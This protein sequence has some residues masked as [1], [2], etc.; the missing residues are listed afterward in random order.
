MGGPGAGAVPFSEAAGAQIRVVQASWLDLMASVELSGARPTEVSRVLKV[1][2]TL[3]WKLSRF[4]SEQEVGKAFRHLPGD[5]GVE[6][7][8]DAVSEHGGDSEKIQSVRTAVT[9]LRAFV[10]AHAG[11]RRTFEAMVHS[12]Q[13][14]G[15]SEV[16]DRKQLYR[17]SS[18]IWSVRALTQMLTI[19]LRPSESKP[20]MID[21]V[22]L[23]GLVEL[24]RLRSEVPWIVRRLRASN[25]NDSDQ[26]SIKREPLD[27]SLASEI[28]A[29]LFLPYCSSPTPRLRQFTDENG[30]VYDEL[31]PGPVGRKGATTCILGEKHIAVLPAEWS[32]E[33]TAGRYS[34]TVR[35]PVQSAMFDLLV[36]KDLTRFDDA[37][38]VTF[39]LLE[40]RPTAGGGTRH[41]QP[42]YDPEP[43]RKLGSPA[44][45]QSARHGWYAGMVEDAVRRAG[46][47]GL[48]NFRGYRM[49]VDYPA[50]PCDLTMVCQINRG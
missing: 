40:G 17:A 33:N 15:Q 19:V 9:E 26:Y 20:G 3:A 44:L 5:A 34:M 31:E 27:S 49:D 8:F 2:K 32:E 25:D 22:Q 13:P 7:M 28:P 47:G 10:K 23:G 18:A 45:V 41:S 50:I 1:D 12:N 43:A 29:P 24:E 16:E 46:W 4:A 35:T 30:W 36:H 11:D 6:I 39:G 42:L 38:M 37:E 14:K 21:V 48:D